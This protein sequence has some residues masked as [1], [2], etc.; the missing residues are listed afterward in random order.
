MPSNSGQILSVESKLK[1]TLFLITKIYHTN[2]EL[3]KPNSFLD[4]LR[5]LHNVRNIQ[6]I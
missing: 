5:I 3:E 2:T 4:L 1:N 6:K